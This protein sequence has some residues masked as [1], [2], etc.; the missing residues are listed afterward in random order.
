MPVIPYLL[1]LSY[2]SLVN[3]LL[4][5]CWHFSETIIPKL[6]SF[7]WPCRQSTFVCKSL[8]G[9]SVVNRRADQ[10]AED[11]NRA[12][13]AC[14]FCAYRTAWY[15]QYSVSPVTGRSLMTLPARSRTN[16]RCSRWRC[17]SLKAFDCWYGGSGSSRSTEALLLKQEKRRVKQPTILSFVVVVVVVMM[18]VVMCW[19]WCVWFE[20]ECAQSLLWCVLKVVLMF[21][22]SVFVVFQWCVGRRRKWEEKDKWE[23]LL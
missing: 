16:L 9:H 3:P 18:I 23:A 7:H 13:F 2:P 14:A 1:E 10:Y 21:V 19:W 22:W 11:L 8:V 17:V 20:S 4:M 12:W 6:S 5:Q 15:C